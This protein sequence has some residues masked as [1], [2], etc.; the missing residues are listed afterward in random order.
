MKILILGLNFSPELIGVGRYTGEMAAWLG[1][2]G[3][4]VRVI[5]APPYY[6][7]WQIEEPYCAKRYR[8]EHQENLT[9]LR[10]PLW[11]PKTPTTLTRILHLLSFALSSAPSAIWQGMTWRPDIVWTVEPT[12]LAAPAAWVSARLGDST[13]CLHIQDLEVEAALGL[14]MLRKSWLI[15]L[16]AWLYGWLLRRFDHVLSLIHI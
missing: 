14:R 11:V 3:H 2:H 15:G 16:S 6:P 1:K 4:D 12:A 9:V 10:C 7:A 8:F 13:A 5:T